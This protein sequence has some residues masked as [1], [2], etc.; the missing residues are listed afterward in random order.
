VTAGGSS[1]VGS[2][3]RENAVCEDNIFLIEEQNW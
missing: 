2:A 3:I 1:F